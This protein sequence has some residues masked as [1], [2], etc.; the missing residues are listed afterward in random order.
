MARAV[1][2][3]YPDA[4]YHVT[5]RGNQRGKVFFSEEHYKLFVEKLGEM[6]MQYGVSVYTYCCMPNHFHLYL[7]TKHAN[8]SKFMQSFLTS[9][10][11]TMNR[12]R[13]SSGHIFQGRY[14][15]HL[16]EDEPY[17]IE[18]SRYIHLNPV[19]VKRLSKRRIEEKR[20]YLYLNRKPTAESRGD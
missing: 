10:C 3:E 7:E 13:N 17:G 16:V 11:V 15:A 2:I 20:E 1:R 14:K 6:A 19:R 8:L 12:L 9:F 18:V 4:C 5:N